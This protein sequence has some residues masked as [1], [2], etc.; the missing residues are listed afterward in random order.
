MNAAQVYIDSPD[1]MKQFLDSMALYITDDCQSRG[2]R[3]RALCD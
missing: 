3:S 1:T 2:W